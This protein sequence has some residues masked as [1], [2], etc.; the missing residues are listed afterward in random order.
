[1]KKYLYFRTGHSGTGTAVA[2]VDATT[3]DLC[4]DADRLVGMETTSDTALTLHFEPVIRHQSDDAG[5]INKDN[6]ILNVAAN[7]Q[8]EVMK[9]ITSAIKTSRVS[10][11]TIADD[12]VD[13]ATTGSIAR[14]IHGSITSCGAIS[15]AS[16][17][18]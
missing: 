16:A 15:V 12:I 3:E 2:D 8:F 6:V 17:Y 9:S 13:D 10:M 5:A 14:Y 4:I 18:S 1:M 7:S 11:V